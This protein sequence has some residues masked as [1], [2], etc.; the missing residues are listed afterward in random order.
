MN[1]GKCMFNSQSMLAQ[2]PHIMLLTDLQMCNAKLHTEEEGCLESP[3]M[4]VRTLWIT[5]Y[6][7]YQCKLFSV[8]TERC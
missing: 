8:L 1:K 4:C 7:T 2:C 3:K 6:I 5:S